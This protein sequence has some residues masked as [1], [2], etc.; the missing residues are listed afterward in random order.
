MPVEV[1]VG[2]VSVVPEARGFGPALQ[3]QITG[4][5][6]DAG[7]AAGGNAG[8]G[9][10]GGMGNV[11]KG[12]VLAVAA[13]AGALFAAGF[14]K[15]VEDDK[16]NAKL[17]AQLG[18]TE[19]ESARAGKIA[20]GVYAKGY[21]ESVEQVNDS[22]RSLAQ[23]GVASIN[24]PKKELAGLSKAALNLA[25][26]F[27]ADVGE[28]A[29]AVGQLIRTGLVKDGKAGFDLL[30]AG[31][32]SG[33]DKGGDLIDTVNEYATQ[34]RK[35][36]L[37]GATGIG[38]INQALQAGARDGDVA[39]DAI[40]EFSIRA[41]DGSDA[42]AGG[43]KALGLNADSMAAKFAKGGSAANGVLDLTLDRLRG[44]KD[45]VEQ[46]AAAVA[47]FGTQS[48][49][50]GSA[51]FAMDPSKAAAGLGKVGGAADKMGKTLHNTATQS[52]EV[53]KRKALQGVATFAAKYALPAVVKFGGFLNTYVLPAAKTAG[54]VLTGTLIP[55]VVTTGSALAAGVEWVR[56]YGA[57]LIP[58]GVAVGGVT[59]A[60]T[61][62]SIATGI[63]IGVIGAYS[64]AI[65]TAAAVTRAWTLVQ[66]GFNAVMA[67][68]PVT[69]IVIGVL[70]LA[71]AVVVA[72]KKSETFRTIV[73]GAWAGIKAGWDVLWTQGLKPGFGAFMT[74]LLAV[75]TAAS[76]LW[77]NVLSPTFSA[78][79]TGGRILATI[80]TI[81][82][83]L[84]IVTA[85]KLL[86]WTA[87]WV[88]EAAI[89]PA[90]RSIA[91][92]ARW[93][94]SMVK[95]QFAL[96]MV[97][98]RALG[99]VGVWLW[100][101]VF[102]PVVGW[103]VG[104]AKLLWTGVRIQFGYITTG[105][106][107][108]GAAGSWL[109]KQAILPAFRGIGTAASWLYTHGIKPHIDKATSLARSLGNA[110]KA[111]ADT[112]GR[113]WK[114]IADKAKTPIRYVV[115]TVYNGAIVPTWNK[116]A[117][118]FG[119]P[120]LKKV[121]AFRRGGPVFGAGTETSDDVPSWLS[122]NEH[123]WTAKEVRG[124]GGHGAVMAMRKWAAA[125]GGAASPGFAKGGG[126][127]DWVGKTASK[128]LDVVKG[129]VS[130]L[131]DGVK[132]S[133]T[134]GLNTVVQPLI[135]K[136]AGSASLYRD[137]VKGIPGR[138]ISEIVGYSGKADKALEKA[139]IGGKGFTAG[140]AWARTQAGKAYQWGGNGDPSWDCSG[141]LSAVESIIRGQRPHR[142]WATGGFSGST[143]PAG[144]VLGARSPYMIGIT[145]S[146][147]GHTAG[148][149]NGTNI[150]SRGGD[151]VLVG[152]RARSYL[153]PMFTHTYGFK[154][155]ANGGSPRPG[156]V[157]WVGEN[158]PE[159]IRFS[160]GEVVY[161]N[162]DS[163]R[164]AAGLGGGVRGF[165][166]GT[167]SAASAAMARRMREQELVRRR[168]G[169]RLPG[170]LGAFTKSLTGSASTIAAAAR[171]LAF[172]L[173]QTGKAGG[174]LVSQTIATTNRLQSLTKRR[175]AVTSQIAAVRQTAAEQ[176]GTAQ[177]YLGLTNINGGKIATV[178]QL[179]SG[180]QAR[181]TTLATHE[182]LIKTGQKKGID[183]SVIQQMIAAGPDSG[184]AGLI[185]GASAGDIKKIN[186]LAKSGAK[187]S[188][189]WGSTVADAMHGNGVNAGLGFLAGLKSQE[190]ALQQQMT[191][192]GGVLVDSIE[193][194]LRIKSPAKETEYVGRMVGAGVVVGTD[195]SIDA[196]RAGAK[197]LGNAAIPPVIPT[198]EAVRAAGQ[199]TPQGGNSYNFYPRTLDMTVRDL[200]LLQRRQDALARV[201]RPR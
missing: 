156:E 47:L 187:L 178:G 114:S 67:L 10:L 6:A 81:V 103:I 141:I 117:S 143:A 15:A 88:W 52:I 7:R 127:F 38:L 68:N 105:I 23:N 179:I 186:S 99:A 75:G 70:A 128:G 89:G 104:G 155:Y 8:S 72:Y 20:G 164:I 136:I 126:L 64:I 119:A 66:V 45:P 109:W 69:L 71:A 61:A 154:G 130:W 121:N 59:L 14:S 83:I 77:S 18:L 183:Q 184:L 85:F 82:V 100:R 78:M 54:G 199:A 24:A 55:A 43:F 53:F 11:L 56:E 191:K 49:D 95:I 125:G 150:E 91:G 113:A 17:G 147:V 180:M 101:S 139:G 181:Q 108:L 33:A 79:S 9:F 94:W 161:S 96:F 145:N 44:I 97:G 41:I 174:S 176:K 40:K 137:M 90:F 80:F 86:A 142:R 192:L 37:D 31:F 46:S 102:S 190:K 21:G 124:A 146:G 169:A 35:A 151:G 182:S 111:G 133:A 198:A 152:S 30:T 12:G 201:G 134:A 93:V 135:N 29:K 168:A 197:R 32:Q 140:L 188:T 42:T 200:E 16:S 87:S 3:R 162:A 107:A 166:K 28:S 73:Q 173:R 159:L 138:M 195:R 98:I 144:W 58:L 76:W 106:R 122:K 74:G 116:V 177:D 19:K 36:G 57:W 157:A 63:T 27:D 153:D 132:A 189:S 131:K 112:V 158:G 171:N 129:G 26:T 48:E 149:L 120:P 172:D 196:V 22:L 62:S 34:W 167:A 148:T 165:A 170:D 118:A 60:M 175:D 50:L 193:K 4:P 5:S 65:R 115:D 160:G 163:M 84:P 2:Y 13:G 185:A 1:G 92:G 51:L 39:A 194:R 25:E 110:F 123:V